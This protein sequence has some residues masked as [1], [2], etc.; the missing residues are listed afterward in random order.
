MKLKA[1]FGR[2]F[3]IK[4]DSQYFYFL[5]VKHLTNLRKII[6]ILDLILVIKE[7]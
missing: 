2:I 3:C 1:K 5:D 7:T 6:K 4:V